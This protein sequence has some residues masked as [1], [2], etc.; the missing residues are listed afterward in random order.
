MPCFI[1]W[2]RLLE[3]MIKCICLFDYLLA[4]MSNVKLYNH[5]EIIEDML[6]WSDKLPESRYL[7]YKYKKSFK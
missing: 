3:P 4:E 2:C 6:Q 1:L 7:I 5:P